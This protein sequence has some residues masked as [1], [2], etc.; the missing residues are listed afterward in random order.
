MRGGRLLAGARRGPGEA[1]LGAGAELGD[2]PRERRAR[3][4]SPAPL[5]CRPVA[6]LGHAGRRPRG[7]GPRRAWPS[8]PPSREGVA[9]QGAADAA[10]VDR[11]RRR[12]PRCA[13]PLAATS[14]V[15]AVGARGDAA[16]DRLADDDRCR[17]RG[18]TP[19]CS[20]PGRRE[21][22]CVSSMI[23][24]APVLAWPARA[25]PSRKPGSGRTMPMLV[26]AGSVRMAATSPWASS[27]STGL[28]VVALDDAR[29]VRSRSTGGRR[30]PGAAG[31]CRRRRAAAKVSST[32]P[33]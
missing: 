27:R 10:D 15:D 2:R 17:A 5:R 16:A 1:V 13:V 25:A 32:E 7:S 3:R 24:S 8:S 30:C 19:R 33:W 21:S 23:S 26:S 11:C 22:V 6:E 14:A 20:R 4:A 31:P 18:P 12:P 9:G 29:V 28:E